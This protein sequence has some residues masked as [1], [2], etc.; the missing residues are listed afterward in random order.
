MRKIF[1]LSLGL[2]L[3]VLGGCA[4]LFHNTLWDANPVVLKSEETGIPQAYR[5]NKEG[6]NNNFKFVY[7]FE[8]IIQ[9]E[10]DGAEVW[11]TDQ[12]RNP[13]K[14]LG[15]TPLAIPCYIASNYNSDHSEDYIVYPKEHLYFESVLVLREER[16]FSSYYDWYG[17]KRG[18]FQNLLIRVPGYYDYFVNKE[19]YTAGKDQNLNSIA[20]SAVTLLDVG[21]F[22]LHGKSIEIKCADGDFIMNAENFDVK[23]KEFIS[24]K[25]IKKAEELKEKRV[26]QLKQAVEREGWNGDYVKEL[27]RLKEIG[28]LPELGK[29]G[30]KE[31]LSK[32]MAKLK[33]D[34]DKASKAG[35]YDKASKIKGL[36]EYKEKNKPGKSLK[37]VSEEA[38]KHNSEGAAY[39][40]QKYYA[41]AVNSL[42][43]SI[44]ADPAYADPYL[45]LSSCYINLGNMQEAINYAEKALKLKPYSPVAFYYLGFAY[46]VLGN[47]PLAVEKYQKA[48]AECAAGECS[49]DFMIQIKKEG[50]EGGLYNS[51][52]AA[53][54]QDRH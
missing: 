52:Q 22:S 51:I 18:M 50:I 49:D 40:R 6:I 45:N 1:L 24:Q 2:I 46:D 14:L 33:E 19:I 42:K 17:I 53:R 3:F 4:N 37:G 23:Q 38:I 12:N 29:P 39:A 44:E 34:L 31:D 15:K 25:K 9:S 27:R 32:D 8:V 7:R 54:A 30:L 28:S 47:H 48:L 26:A 43:K 10:P 35:D 20:S 41:D 16:G 36:I 13:I 5:V 11:Q 21:A